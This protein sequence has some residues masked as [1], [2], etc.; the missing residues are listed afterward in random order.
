M[1][2]DN[3]QSTSGRSNV[4]PGPES[5]PI[6]GNIESR[7]HARRFDTRMTTRGIGVE[8]SM[9]RIANVLSSASF[10]S[11][12][13]NKSTVDTI[14]SKF[15]QRFAQLAEDSEQFDN[16]M[17][18]VFG[19]SID[20]EKA[21]SLQQQTLQGDFSWLPDIKLVDKETLQGAYGA[22][23]AE[24]H[25]VYLDEAMVKGAMINGEAHT[26]IDLVD[27]YAEEVGHSLDQVF[28]LVDT[29]GDEGELFRRLLSGENLT[30]AELAV[31]RLEDD[32]GVLA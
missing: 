13:S 28:N 32:H 22:Y 2:P 14:K 27:V 31:I 4:I 7:R 11:P 23:S 30:A 6:N 20:Q 9:A 12:A 24:N 19:S 17:L 21:E 15:Q 3:I 1:L 18:L 8:Q 29:A 10:T 26:E 16:L 25:L 5:L